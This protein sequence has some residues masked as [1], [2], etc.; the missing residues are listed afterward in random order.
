MILMLCCSF[1][2][3]AGV[4]KCKAVNGRVTYSQKPCKG[5]NQAFGLKK[6]K[7]PTHAY[8]PSKGELDTQRR[9]RI[10]KESQK[11][12]QQQAKKSASDRELNSFRQ[13]VDRD[14]KHREFI[15]AIKAPIV[16]KYR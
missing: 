10:Y 8:I 13:T 9:S 5:S 12:R 6:N 1:S 4:F 3:S 15:E 16:I 2:V 7:A 11:K 14:M